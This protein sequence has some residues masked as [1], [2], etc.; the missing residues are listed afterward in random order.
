MTDLI[1]YLWV[2]VGVLLS[3]LLPIAAKWLREINNED[4]KGL[5]D[6]AKKVGTFAQ[7]YFKIMLASMIISLLALAVYRAGLGGNAVI[8]NWAKAVIYGYTWDSTFQKVFKN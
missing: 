6:I 7:P 8:D 5:G 2:V 3:T 1:L 4:T